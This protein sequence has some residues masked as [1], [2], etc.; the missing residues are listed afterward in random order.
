MKTADLVER[1]LR[2][3]RSLGR[4]PKTVANYRY[5]LEALAREVRRMPED[6][7]P[8]EQFLGGLSL[9]PESRYD[10]WRVLR[11]FFGW[12]AARHG[13]A[14]P[15]EEIP[16]PQRDRG[17]PRSLTE[18]QVQRVFQ[19][20]LDKTDLGLVALALDTGA[21]VGEISGAGKGDIGTSTVH[22]DGKTGRREVPISQ[23]VR[24]LLL[25][26]GDG[27][28]LWVGR[29]GPLTRSGVELRFRRVLARAGISPP[30]AGPHVLR[31]TFG[32]LYIKNGGNV[33]HLQR[34]LG[35]ASIETTMIYVQMQTADLVQAHR[36]VSPV[37]AMWALPLAELTPQR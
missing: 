22:L 26:L 33:V 11:T 23:E 20:C 17:Y 37:R 5:I 28:R 9:A 35:H 30:K 16:A 6:P 12:C 36:D 21:R 15:M 13:T 34:I 1:F 32:R 4:R 2:Q 27:D 10:F 14:N 3:R 7:E 19:S 18:S 31:H 25:A 24:R 29:K 8:I